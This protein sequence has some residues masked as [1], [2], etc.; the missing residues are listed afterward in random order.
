LVW[1]QGPSGSDSGS[2]DA[3]T[4]TH[5]PRNDLLGFGKNLLETESTNTVTEVLSL[6]RLSARFFKRLVETSVEVFSRPGKRL[7]CFE[8]ASF[9]SGL[10]GS[11]QGFERSGVGRLSISFG[12]VAVPGGP[13]RLCQD[14]IPSPTRTLTLSRLSAFLVWRASSRT[15]ARVVRTVLA[16]SSSHS[17]SG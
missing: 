16:R 7:H 5:L 17:P 8:S 9:R 2:P 12:K 4:R 14:R 6:L 15:P 10:R 11:N 13:L 3:Q 1:D